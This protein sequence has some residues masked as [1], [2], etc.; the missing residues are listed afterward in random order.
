MT[1]VTKGRPRKHY[2]GSN[3]GLSGLT[4]TG[5]VACPPPP[6]QYTSISSLC[7]TL[8]GKFPRKVPCLAS[9]NLY[10]GSPSLQSKTYSFRRVTVIEISCYCPSFYHKT[11]KIHQDSCSSLIHNADSYS[12][13]SLLRKHEHHYFFL[14]FF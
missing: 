10:S 14:F 9:V 3:R 8:L 6:P 4:S 11:I 2:L 5:V 1:I 12:C 13:W 7:H